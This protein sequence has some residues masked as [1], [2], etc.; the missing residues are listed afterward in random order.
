MTR[1]LNLHPPKSVSGQPQSCPAIYLQLGIDSEVGDLGG[2]QWDRDRVNDTG[3]GSLVRTIPR[4][5]N[6]IP[7]KGEILPQIPPEK[8]KFRG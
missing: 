7:G 2:G 6:G 1:F 4:A 8:G 3:R 5:G